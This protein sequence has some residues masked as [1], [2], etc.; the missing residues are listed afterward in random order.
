[1]FGGGGNDSLVGEKGDDLFD[2]GK[3]NDSLE[4]KAGADTYAFKSGFGRDLIQGFTPG[5]DE[6]D[7]SGLDGNLDFGDLIFS[8]RGSLEIIR[9]PD[10]SDHIL[11]DVSGSQPIT[12]SDFIFG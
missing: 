4:G 11:I 9:V 6:I 3:G 1:L 5:V 7:L 2:G 12:A 8:S 10:T